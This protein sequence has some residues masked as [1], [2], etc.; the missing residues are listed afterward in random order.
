MLAVSRRQPLVRSAVYLGAMGSNGGSPGSLRGWPGRWPGSLVLDTIGR[1]KDRRGQIAGLAESDRATALGR[2]P[3]PRS[4]IL[5]PYPHAQELRPVVF[6][7]VEA[8]GFV[9]F[10]IAAGALELG[11]GL[12][13]RLRGRGPG[14]GLGL[15]RVI[16]ITP[17][18]RPPPLW[19]PAQNPCRRSGESSR[20][21][22]RPERSRDHRRRIALAR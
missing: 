18:V 3:L 20:K 2:P 10:S 12:P 19:P 5:C 7:D 13:R 14:F 22:T 4:K 11:H 6:V 15:G 1:L 9:G 21:G 16:R 8:Q 17:H